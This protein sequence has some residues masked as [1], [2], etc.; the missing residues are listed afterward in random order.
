MAA[1]VWVLEKLGM[2]RAEHLLQNALFKERLH[3][4]YAYALVRDEWLSSRLSCRVSQ[5]RAYS[6]RLCA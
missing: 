3:D 1:S 6:D 2:R 4:E 5:P